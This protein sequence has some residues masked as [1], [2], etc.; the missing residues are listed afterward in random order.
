MLNVMKFDPVLQP[1]I[2]IGCVIC[3]C[4]FESV[5]VVC[6]CHSLVQDELWIT[7]Y[8]LANIFNAKAEAFCENVYVLNE[9]SLVCKKCW[10]TFLL[11]VEE[12]LK[13]TS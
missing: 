4:K 5:Y 8:R 2:E 12:R 3:G 1:L 13:V 10:V 7:V 6:D 9:Q 11:Q